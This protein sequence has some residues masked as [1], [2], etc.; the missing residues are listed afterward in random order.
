MQKSEF[1]N[2]I[3]DRKANEWRNAIK[4]SFASRRRAEQTSRLMTDEIGVSL[5]GDDKN[6]SL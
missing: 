4:V 5:I 2:R 3:A 1:G 6:I